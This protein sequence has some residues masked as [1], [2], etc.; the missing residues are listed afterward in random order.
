VIPSRGA[1]RRT[2]RP[3][4]SLSAPPLK[5]RVRELIRN[6]IVIV[7]VVSLA[8]ALALTLLWTLTPLRDEL[9]P[10]NAAAWISD[11]ASRWWTPW[12]L[13]A[14]IVG[15]NLFVFPRP[16]LTIAAVVAY[17]FWKGLALSLAGA[18]IGT[19]IGWYMGRLFSR[20]HVERLL[21]PVMPRMEPLLRRNG[22]FA[23]TMLRLLPLGPHA[24]GSMASGVFRIRPWQVFAGTLIGMAPGIVGSA[25]V[26]QQ[27]ADGMTADG[28]VNHW[29]LWGAVAGVV[30]L[31]ALT[32]FWYQRVSSAGEPNPS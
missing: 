10:G 3:A 29:I 15:A 31:L 2:A 7:T 14:L 21:G 27:L 26:G 22:L 25:L 20:E 6:P 4:E 23:M 1:A 32:R 5:V 13:L 19:F 16:L 11:I 17:G 24:L 9:T 30:V 28:H 18:E 8:V 12:L